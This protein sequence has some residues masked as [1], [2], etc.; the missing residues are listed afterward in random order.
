MLYSTTIVVRLA[1]FLNYPKALFASWKLE[2]LDP[3]TFDP[4]PLTPLR[5][6]LSKIQQRPTVIIDSSFDQHIL[7]QPFLSFLNM[8]WRSRVISKYI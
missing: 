6:M 3:L 1:L 7:E 8:K 2:G 5:P 4:R